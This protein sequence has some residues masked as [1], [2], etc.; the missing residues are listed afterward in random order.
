MVSLVLV[1]GS[2]MMVERFRILVMTVLQ[3]V[4]RMLLLL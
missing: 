2:R 1:L 3:C 4:R